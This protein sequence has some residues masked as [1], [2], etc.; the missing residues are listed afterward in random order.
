MFMWGKNTFMHDRNIY[1]NLWKPRQQQTISGHCKNCWK[2]NRGELYIWSAGV[3]SRCEYNDP[4]QKA[5][6]WNEWKDKAC[7]MK[8]KTLSADHDDLAHCINSSKT[9]VPAGHTGEQSTLV[10]FVCCQATSN[11]K[12]L[13][14]VYVQARVCETRSPLC[15]FSWLKQHFLFHNSERLLDGFLKRTRLPELCQNFCPFNQ[16]G[17][18]TFRRIARWTLFPLLV[19]FHCAASPI[20]LSRNADVTGQ[21]LIIHRVCCAISSEQNSVHALIISLKPILVGV[22]SQQGISCVA[23]FCWWFRVSHQP[24]VFWSGRMWKWTTDLLVRG[25]G[26]NQFTTTP[27]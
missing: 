17:W 13:T 8:R 26:A 22:P 6:R 1:S 21:I 5:P 11:L 7:R 9:T 24:Q 15:L 10:P 20:W 27:L 18:S 16:A 23:C 14:G 4:K 12:L 3:I 25:H 2:L 19:A